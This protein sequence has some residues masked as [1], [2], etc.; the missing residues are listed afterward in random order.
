VSNRPRL[1]PRPPGQVEAR[2]RDELR[3]EGC[4][5]CGSR[6]VTGKFVAETNRWEFTLR[7]P[8]ACGTFTNPLGAFTAHATAAAAARRMGMD[9]KAFRGSSGGVVVAA[10][11]GG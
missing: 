7:C 3:R 5:E 11:P 4:P 9:Y 8:A 2:F 1:K 10:Q 6:I